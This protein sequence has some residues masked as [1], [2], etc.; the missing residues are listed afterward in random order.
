MKRNAQLDLQRG[1]PDQMIAPSAENN[2][3]C[4]YKIAPCAD[5][6]APCAYKNAPCAGEVDWPAAC[7]MFAD[8]QDQRENY[9]DVMTTTAVPAAQLDFT[10]IYRGPMDTVIEEAPEACLYEYDTYPEEQ[11]D[12]AVKQQ[13]QLTWADGAA[14]E[15]KVLSYDESL[16]AAPVDQL[17]FEEMVMLNEPELTLIADKDGKNI[18]DGQ[19]LYVSGVNSGSSYRPRF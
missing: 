10:D 1:V 18:T 6:N 15:Q 5:K 14:G 3:P 2:A 4:A 12:E 17:D 11:L 19:C 13:F 9:Y 16:V 8:L 7:S